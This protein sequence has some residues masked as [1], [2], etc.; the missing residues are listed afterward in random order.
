M[1]FTFWN[2]F[3]VCLFIV[4]AVGIVV[5]VS[6]EPQQDITYSEGEEEEDCWSDLGSGLTYV[7]DGCLY[8][9]NDL[10]YIN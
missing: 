2:Y 1:R 3:F 4:I 10:D 6:A 8:Y 9:I 7:P 5:F